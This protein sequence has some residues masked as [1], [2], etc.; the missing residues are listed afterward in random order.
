MKITKIS[1]STNNRDL[2]Q[3]FVNDEFLCSISGNDLLESR[4]ATNDELDPQKIELLLYKSLKGKLASAA[5]RYLGSRPHS[6]NEIRQYLKRK[7]FTSYKETPG[8]KDTDTEKILNEITDSLKQNKYLNDEEFAKWL[9]AQRTSSKKG[10][11]NTAIRAELQAK[12]IDP[13]T[14]SNVLIDKGGESEQERAISIAEKKLELL[15]KRDSN[16]KDIRI[17]LTR[18]LISKG[19][20]WDTTRSAVD[21]LLPPF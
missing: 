19:F 10:K 8:Y 13:E 18:Y 20:P 5:F 21:S 3:I 4:L 6:E 14:V 1:P 15:K 9:V 2:Y 11:S 12:G 16:D 17:K 7:L